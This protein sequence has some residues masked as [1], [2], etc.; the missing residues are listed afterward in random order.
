MA[1]NAPCRIR[2]VFQRSSTTLKILLLAALVVCTLTLLALRFALLSEKD[3]A[4]DLRQQAVALEQEN[5]KLTRRNAL[6]GTVQSV[7]EL[8]NE[9]LGLVDP[10]TIIFEPVE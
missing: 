2:L 1:R 9:L 4:E 3:K 8:A 10:D 5:Q 7:Q 6:L